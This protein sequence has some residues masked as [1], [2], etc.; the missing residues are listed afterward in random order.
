PNSF[1]QTEQGVE[2]LL[3]SAYNK[4]YNNALLSRDYLTPNAM[5]T[6]ILWDYGGGYVN[7]DSLYTNFEWDS[8]EGIFE[9]IWRSYYEGIRNAN[10][11]LENIHLAESSFSEDDIKDI[12]AEARFIRAGDYYYL[13]QIFGSVPLVTRSD[14]LNLTPSRPT[15]E[16]FNS[17]LATELQEAANNLPLTH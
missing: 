12:I 7:I 15:K 14:S 11:L 3:H 9:K 5:P 10:S 1:L 16:E 13:W 8:Q 4:L 2:S 6:G 17:F